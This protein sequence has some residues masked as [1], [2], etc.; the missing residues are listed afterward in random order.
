MVQLKHVHTVCIKLNDITTFIYFAAITDC[1][2][3]PSPINGYVNFSS[4]GVFS[5]ATYHC[6]KDHKLLGFDSTQCL[7]GGRWSGVVPLCRRK[8]EICAL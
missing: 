8:L 4:T 5:V 7:M 3:P 2:I 1:G 6:N